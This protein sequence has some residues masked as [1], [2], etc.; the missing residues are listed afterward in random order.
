LEFC[1][2]LLVHFYVSLICISLRKSVF[3][4]AFYGL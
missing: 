1:N 2:R 4:K 3:P